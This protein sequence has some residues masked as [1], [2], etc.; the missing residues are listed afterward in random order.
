M[1]P[2]QCAPLVALSPYTQAT[3]S[4]GQTRPPSSLDVPFLRAQLERIEATLSFL[5]DQRSAITARLTE[6]VALTSPVR[7]LSTELLSAI[8]VACVEPS[9]SG[10]HDTPALVST[11]MLVCRQWRDVCLGTPELWCRINISPNE[12]ESLEKTRRRL[13]R[14][15]AV[16]LDIFLDFSP[17]SSYSAQA[18]TTQAWVSPDQLLKTSLVLLRPTI[19]RWRTFLLYV[20]YR[21]QATAALALCSSPAPLLESLSIQVSNPMLHANTM[22]WDTDRAARMSLPFQGIT[23][24]LKACSLTSFW[25]ERPEEA[26]NQHAQQYSAAE[27]MRRHDVVPTHAVWSRMVFPG[28][29]P[30][31]TRLRLIGFWND[32]APNVDEMLFILRQCPLLEDLYIRNLSDVDP[33]DVDLNVPVRQPIVLAH[34]HRLSF[35]YSGV[36]RTCALLHGTVLPALEHLELA[37]LDN[38]T[39]CLKY[40]KQ[41]TVL[42]SGFDNVYE[43]EYGYRDTAEVA[44]FPLK[45]MRVEASLFSELKFLRLLRRLPF[46][47]RLDL[48]DIEDVSG[49]LLKVCSAFFPNNVH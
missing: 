18:P 5:L 40:L 11:L 9:H 10:P 19:S 48:V 20:P 25:C 41:Q 6:A 16:P 1:P 26:L 39:A 23:P 35:Y 34:L 17:R 21:P 42:H 27:G 44:L 29:S 8:F 7:L 12:P 47:E 24:R 31:L 14:S 33:A 2:L 43:Y 49:N 32:F 15:K 46:L 13:A 45:S 28:V 4:L 38:I 22:E 36:T 37:F 3:L 30:S